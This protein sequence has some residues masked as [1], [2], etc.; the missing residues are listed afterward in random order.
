MATIKRCTSFAH[1]MLTKVH[2]PTFTKDPCFV[3][4][5]KIYLPINCR[6]DE[7]CTRNKR[8]SYSRFWQNF[9]LCIHILRS[10]HDWFFFLQQ[11]PM[12]SALYISFYSIQQCNLLCRLGHSSQS[13]FN[14]NLYSPF[15]RGKM[16]GICLKKKK[17]RNRIG[18]CLIPSRRAFSCTDPICTK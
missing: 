11:L 1:P 8:H 5:R 6:R 18:T 9:L 12:Y 13:M 14:E 16:K 10:L 4:E 7:R 2:G 17:K 15:Y 3:N